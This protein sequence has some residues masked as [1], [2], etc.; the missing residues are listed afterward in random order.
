MKKDEKK[1]TEDKN[2][3]RLNKYIANAGICSRREADEMIEKGLV[4]V[5]GETVK[6]MGAKVSAFDK[7]SIQ[8]KAIKKNE[9]KIYILLN[10][11]KDCIT[12]TKDPGERKTIMHLVRSLTRKRVYPVGRLDRNSTGLLLLT[13]DGEL[14]QQL[15]H[16]SSKI[17]KIYAVELDKALKPHDLE[18]II[19]GIKLDDGLAQV[20]KI[21]FTSTENN[22]EVGIE[23]HSGKNRI[24]RRIFES[25]G[26]DVKK[27][28]RV[29]FAGL[30]KQNL[31]R[32]KA[33]F[34]NDREVRFLK[35]T[36]TKASKA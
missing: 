10:K 28:D 31:P 16:P 33:R 24:I 29:L 6:K 17:A 30:T 2:L 7:I 19:A 4:S 27:L 12:T 14:T 1:T 20:D 32:G 25:L 23:L 21:A 22:K 36:V 8:G 11:P 26:Y 13:N 18:K 9:E 35:N 5:N 3:I 15:I 34:L